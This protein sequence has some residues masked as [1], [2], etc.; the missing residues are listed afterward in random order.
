M[1]L[2]SSLFERGSSIA[3]EETTARLASL[4]LNKKTPIAASEL[5][6]LKRKHAFSI[7]ANIMRDPQF[8]PKEREKYTNDFNGLLT[9]HGIDIWRHV[10][11]WTIDLTQPG[12]IERKMEEC[13]WTNTIIYA[14]GGWSKETGF[15]ANFFF[16]H[17]VT[18]SLF[19]PSL[20]SYLSQDSQVMLLRAYFTTA[21]AW[22][23]SRGGPRLDIHR[24]LDATSLSP[25]SEDEVPSRANSFLDIIQSGI[26]HPDDHMLKIQRAFA[27]FSSRYGGR[28]K[29][30][31]KGTELEGAEALDGTLFLR[32]ARLTNDY[33][34]QGT[35][36]WSTD[37]SAMD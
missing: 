2:P 15:T 32:A 20:L 23:I 6:Q 4:L 9:V 34:N 3:V 26:T 24:F 8:A 30:Y 29:G 1:F 21:L 18:S 13:I 19:L 25:S 37:F 35:G 33:M 27:H 5:D 28:P 17:L 7:L 36:S 22:L 12:E 16:M 31:F 14:I 11:Q 10:E